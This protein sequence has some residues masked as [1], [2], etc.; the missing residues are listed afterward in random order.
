MPCPTPP[1]FQAH[2]SCCQ[3]LNH[4]IGL[5]WI[6]LQVFPKFFQTS[7]IWSQLAPYLSLSNTQKQTQGGSQNEETKKQVPNERTE[8]TPTKELS[9]MEISNLTDAEFKILLIRM[10]HELSEN[11]GELSEGLK[12]VKKDQSE[13]MDA[14]LELK[15]HKLK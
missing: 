3:L 13:I 8:Q 9:E 4:R 15:R 6:L 14:Q 11:L 7:S 12:S 5:S 10:L 2:P 1:N